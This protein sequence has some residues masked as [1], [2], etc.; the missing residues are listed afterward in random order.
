VEQEQQ[1]KKGIASSVFSFFGS[2]TQK[3]TSV[4][5]GP[6]EVLSLKR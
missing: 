3:V 6:G 5:T 1:Q 2:A 4:L